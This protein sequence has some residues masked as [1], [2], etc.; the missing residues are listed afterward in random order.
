[1]KTSSADNADD[2]IVV[3]YF[4]SGADASRAIA[5]LI[6]EG[7]RPAEIGAAFRGS[8]TAMEVTEGGRRRPLAG[9]PATT[10]ST[11]GPSSHDEAVTPAGLASGAGANFPS[12]SRPGPIT[13]AE[14]PSTLRHDLP[15]TLRHESEIDRAPVPAVSAA[16]GKVPTADTRE[17]DEVRRAQMRRFFGEFGEGAGARRASGMKFG[18]GE[19]YLFPDYEFS[20]PSFENSFLGMGLSVRDA[21]S[22]SHELSR[23]GAIVSIAAISRAS[24]AE[25][26][27]QRNRGVIRFESLA[28]E[29]SVSEGSSVEIY[30]RMRNYY[31]PE[32]SARRKAS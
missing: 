24:L 29:G 5:E 12:A 4:F 8:A 2:R 16:R 18:T 19:G 6:D 27:L 3:G 11:G 22:L 32:E 15:S 21:R 13:G 20:E 28:A 1:M 23:G 25:G 30:G 26:I 31:R 17:T 14:I 9:N 10:G 7:F